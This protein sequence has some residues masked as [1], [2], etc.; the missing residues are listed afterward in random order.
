MISLWGWQRLAS[1]YEYLP[2]GGGNVFL[3]AVVHETVY[4]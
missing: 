1:E 4:N 3:L 2:D